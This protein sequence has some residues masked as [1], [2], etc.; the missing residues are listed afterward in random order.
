M[1]A[2]GF[3]LLTH[4]TSGSW[5]PFLMVPL[6]LGG[7]ATSVIL[8]MSGIKGLIACSNRPKARPDSGTAQLLAP[9]RHRK[10][11]VLGE[12]ITLQG[13]QYAT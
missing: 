3:L 6:V 1:P 8:M 5:I 9:A 11:V 4:S 13:D 7:L 2:F 10:V 12:E